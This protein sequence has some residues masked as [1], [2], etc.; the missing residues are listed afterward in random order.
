M[1]RVAASIPK[2]V[3]D[4]K[5]YSTE[6]WNFQSS[7]EL[8]TTCV[9]NLREIDMLNYFCKLCFSI[10]FVKVWNV[11]LALVRAVSVPLKEQVK[12]LVTG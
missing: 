11:K 12:K 10:F 3:D 7:M 8:C 5:S 4:F 2:L 6:Y 9:L 1:K